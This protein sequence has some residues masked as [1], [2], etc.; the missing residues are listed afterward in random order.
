MPFP[1]LSI[2]YV[3]EPAKSAAFYGRILGREP[4]AKSPNF[5]VFDL[6][7]GFK[8]GLLARA[9]VEPAAPQG[10]SGELCFFVDDEERLRGLHQQWADLGVA[11]AF[12]PKLM[13]FGSHNFMALD[14][15]GNRLRVST[16]DKE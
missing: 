1:T 15:D 16:P 4:A 6:G 10:C 3:T 8:L 12:P 13:Y 7:Q 14:P 9:T 11:M 5:V 2:L